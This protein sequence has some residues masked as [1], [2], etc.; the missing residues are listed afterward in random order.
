MVN[1]QVNQE[2]GYLDIERPDPEMK[3][4]TVESISCVR[5]VHKSWTTITGIFVLCNFA[6]KTLGHVILLSNLGD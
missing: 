3:I 2:H 6:Y 1:I 4:N 5:E